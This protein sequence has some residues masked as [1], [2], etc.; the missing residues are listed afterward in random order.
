MGLFNVKIVD[1]QELKGSKSLSLLSV[2]NKSF[3]GKISL[4]T[5]SISAKNYKY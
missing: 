3:N 2:I 4:E 5:L 1:E